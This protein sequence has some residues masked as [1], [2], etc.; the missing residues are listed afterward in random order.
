MA[1]NPN[2]RSILDKAAFE[3]LQEYYIHIFGNEASPLW[4]RDNA[5]R[6]FFS[7]LFFPPKVN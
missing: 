5:R 7:A 1:W 3:K 6:G 4:E 2:S